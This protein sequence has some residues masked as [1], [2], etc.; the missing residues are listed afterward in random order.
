MRQLVPHDSDENLL[1]YLRGK[2]FNVSKAI[3]LRTTS[4]EWWQDERA[5]FRATP[6]TLQDHLLHRRLASFSDCLDQRGRPVV[7][8]D[9]SKHTPEYA[10]GAVAA[11]LV[12]IEAAL[13]VSPTGD[14]TV[15]F[16]LRSYS[17]QN[18]DMK[19]ARELVTSLSNGFPERLG[20][21]V[22][23]GAPRIFSALWAV[24]RGFIDARTASKIHFVKNIAS[25]I[26]VVGAASVPPSLG[27]QDFA[28][29]Q[30]MHDF[31]AKHV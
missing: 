3:Q 26:A 20:G 9:A 7:V 27:G 12:I 29:N 4:L 30:R 15:V 24:I 1:R 18:A 11:L 23:V 21:A 17:N 8:I 13:A 14:I 25:C 16:D 2:G 6:A 28:A 5:K 19:S 10:A 22:I 31:V